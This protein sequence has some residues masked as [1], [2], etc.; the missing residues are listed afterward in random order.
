MSRGLV[1]GHVNQLHLFVLSHPGNG[2]G[3]RVVG[4]NLPL[5]RM[6]DDYRSDAPTPQL[7]GHVRC[8]RVAQAR[9]VY[10]LTAGRGGM[11]MAGAKPF[12]LRFS[13]SAP[14]RSHPSPFLEHVITRTFH[15]NHQF[16]LY[17][18]KKG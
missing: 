9:G 11:L 18:R 10:L 1:V 12:G 15:A 3:N 8:L 2:L 6:P 17:R 5:T 4:G 7:A 13:A 14:L 16:H